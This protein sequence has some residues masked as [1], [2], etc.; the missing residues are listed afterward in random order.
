MAS[1]GSFGVDTPTGNQISRSK[2][3]SAEVA[4]LSNAVG[5]KIEGTTFGS[6]V[7]EEEEF[8]IAAAIPA[9][10]AVDAQNGVNVVLSDVQNEVNNDYAKKTISN[11]TYPGA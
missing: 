6:E 3:Q 9:Q 8:F 5:V 7:V 4:V 2:S 11:T 10:T 1:A